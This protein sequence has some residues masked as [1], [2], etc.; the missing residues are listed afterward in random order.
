MANGYVNNFALETEAVLTSG[1]V[2]AALQVN[3]LTV[4]S[5]NIVTGKR[6]YAEHMFNTEGKPTAPVASGDLVAIKYAKVTAGMTS[7]L[8]GRVNLTY[9]D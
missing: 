5:G 8:Y 6:A 1:T 2:G 7:Y 4:A 3:G 9:T